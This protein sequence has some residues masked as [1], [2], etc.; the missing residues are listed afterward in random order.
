MNRKGDEPQ[1]SI[2]P[3]SLNLMVEELGERVA[4]HATRAMFRILMNGARDPRGLVEA[5]GS[6]DEIASN[7]SSLS[8][9]LH[10]SG[11]ATNGRIRAEYR[12]FNQF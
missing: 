2:L 11:G 1:L 8:E 10:L 3:R 12:F 9:R 4:H 6:A 5:F 7:G